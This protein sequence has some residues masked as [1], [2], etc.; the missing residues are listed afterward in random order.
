MLLT[1]LDYQRETM[2]WK[3]EGLTDEQARHAPGP[4]ENSI[5]GLIQHLAHVERWWFRMCF[6]GEDL[7]TPWAEGDRDAD[8]RVPPG[9]PVSEVIE[10]YRSECRRAN[11]IVGAAPSLDDLSKVASHGEHPSLRWILLHMIEETARHAGHADITR[12]LVDGVTG[13]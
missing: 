10:F 6:A 5:A 12:E 9:T 4:P 3:A 1:F 11:E 2:I 13:Y 8:F 7:E